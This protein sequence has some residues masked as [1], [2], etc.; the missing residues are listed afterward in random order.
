MIWSND[1]KE[2]EYNAEYS[3]D[4]WMTDGGEWGIDSVS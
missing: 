4:W 2:K 3:A 1:W